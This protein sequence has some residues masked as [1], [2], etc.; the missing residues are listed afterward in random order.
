M[1]LA[2]KAVWRSA[3]VFIKRIDL[4]HLFE[5]LAISWSSTHVLNFAEIVIFADFE[6]IFFHKFVFYAYI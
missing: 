3:L 6:A 2:Q 1:L 5:K 4:C